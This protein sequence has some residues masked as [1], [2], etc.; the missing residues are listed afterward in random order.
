MCMKRFEAY[1]IPDGEVE[2]RFPDS[3]ETILLQS[4]E[5]L[6]FSADLLEELRRRYPMMVLAVEQKIKQTNRSVYAL[7]KSNRTMY[8][9]HMGHCI[10]S[11][12]FGERDSVLDFDG[13]R[14]RMERPDCCRDFKFCPWNGY[15]ETNADN[16][17]VICGAKREYGFTPTERKIAL[18]VQ[19]EI[20]EPKIMGE[21]LGMTQK[22]VWN[23]LSSIY[24]KTC[25]TGMPEL[26]IELQHENI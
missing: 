4:S 6:L 1:I 14:F 22:S 20:T 26:I 5:G 25:V 21:L 2:I 17:M 3:Q 12:C 10:C 23:H 9:Q 11:C 7:M 24:K 16:F 18:C 8:L 19:R 15:R 13:K